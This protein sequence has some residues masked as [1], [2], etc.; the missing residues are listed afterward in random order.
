MRPS[1]ISVTSQKILTESKEVSGMS[2]GSGHGQSQVEEV[3][4]DPKPGGGR[5]KSSEVGKFRRCPWSGSFGEVEGVAIRS[6]MPRIGFAPT[7]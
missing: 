2:G 6:E 1:F 5:T 3:A 4:E 7:S